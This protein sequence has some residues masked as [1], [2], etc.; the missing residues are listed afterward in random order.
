VVVPLFALGDWNIGS[1]F[2]EEFRAQVFTLEQLQR[3]SQTGLGVPEHTDDSL[4]E[5]W[6]RVRN[7]ASAHFFKLHATE[8]LFARNAA[9][10]NASAAADPAGFAAKSRQPL[11]S[12]AASERSWTV[13]LRYNPIGKILAAISAPGLTGYAPRAWDGAALQC[14][15]RLSYEIRRQGIEAVGVPAFLARH[16][17]WSTHPG[18]GRPLLWNAKDGELRVQTMGRQPAGRRFSIRIWQPHSAG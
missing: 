11:E 17:E 18:D 7:I 9:Q 4:L 8:N 2:A 12:L 13:W 1:V 6:N 10:L 3:A 16:P 5:S 15:V 14:L